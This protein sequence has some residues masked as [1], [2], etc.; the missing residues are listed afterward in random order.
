MNAGFERMVAET[1]GVCH[2][3]MLGPN[4]SELVAA[5]R[6][7]FKVPSSPTQPVATGF[8]TVFSTRSAN[9][10]R[11]FEALRRE[12]GPAAESLLLAKEVTK[13]HMNT[14]PFEE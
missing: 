12:F 5:E 4:L 6:S 2:L 11:L 7:T 3:K 9:A 10:S 8:G 14:S 13:K 1:G